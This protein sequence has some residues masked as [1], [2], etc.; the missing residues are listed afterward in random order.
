MTS[1]VRRHAAPSPNASRTPSPQP[2]DAEQAQPVPRRLVAGD[3]GT[4]ARQA[5]ANVPRAGASLLEQLPA[6][7]LQTAASKLAPSDVLALG[8]TSRTVSQALGAEV[9]A[10]RVVQTHAPAVHT[11][12][13]F[14]AVLGPGDPRSVAALPSHLQ[15]EPLAAVAGRVMALAPGEQ[16]QA[17]QNFQAFDHS[18]E[19]TPVP[20]GCAAANGI[21]SCAAARLPTPSSS[22]Q[23]T[24]R[25]W[26]C[27]WAFPA[28]AA[29]VIT[30][31]MYFASPPAASRDGS[32]GQHHC[33]G[34]FATAR[35]SCS[36]FCRSSR[37]LELQN[38]GNVQQAPKVRRTL[39]DGLRHDFEHCGHVA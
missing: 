31:P 18:G 32:K 15:A 13:R 27:V 23:R 6:T 5:P 22:A 3:Q 26:H 29:V 2:A 33:I 10:A 9:R 1:P 21:R 37:S 34:S 39:N 7:V 30:G 25:R 12:A 35:Q 24:S 17:I 8:A 14:N 4:P 36:C 16:L 19:P 28:G 20:P 38:Q 11:L